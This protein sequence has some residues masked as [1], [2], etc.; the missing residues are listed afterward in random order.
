MSLQMSVSDQF[1]RHITN[2]SSMMARFG[3]DPVTLAPE[4]LGSAMRA[5]LACQSGEVCHDCLA[6]MEISPQPALSFCPNAPVFEQARENEARG[7]PLERPSLNTISM[8]YFRAREV[9]RPYCEGGLKDLGWEGRMDDPS[10]L[11]EI[12]CPECGV[13]MKPEFNAYEFYGFKEK[14]GVVW[15]SVPA[16][17][18]G[19]RPEYY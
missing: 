13:K 11:K 16:H 7:H 5:C 14:E 4:L 2:M 19:K 12:R 1:S 18:P 3:V 6:Q 10:R 17:Y 9:P 15:A 8:P